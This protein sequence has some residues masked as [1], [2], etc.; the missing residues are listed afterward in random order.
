MQFV[1]KTLLIAIVLVLFAVAINAAQTE[2]AKPRS[3]VW[4][5]LDGGDGGSDGGDPCICPAG[6]QGNVG[7][8][9]PKGN[10]GPQGP[11]GAQ[12]SVGPDGPIGVIGNVG[13]QGPQ[14]VQGPQGIQG[15]AGPA[16]GGFVAEY[17]VSA[18]P[19]ALLAWSEFVLSWPFNDP[20]SA[21]T[22]KQN[23]TLGVVPWTVSYTSSLPPFTSAGNALSAVKDIP[24]SP[25]WYEVTATISFH[26]V[27][28]PGMA[29]PCRAAVWTH[30][31]GASYTDLSNTR[32]YF[33]QF[34]TAQNGLKTLRG[35]SSVAAFVYVPAAPAAPRVLSAGLVCDH[36]VNLCRPAATAK[37]TLQPEGKGP[38]TSTPTRVQI[39]SRMQL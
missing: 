12:G 6:L 37:F 30:L 7:P 21:N 4:R 22:L 24:L 29:G 39:F 15:I 23:A 25:G 13:S 35:V 11:N 33:G 8:Q 19:P 3:G 16:S 1:G 18:A 5:R 27:V 34:E 28:P 20:T 14:G 17:G 36:G 32:W 2:K 38:G 26:S 31:P 9:G 10:V